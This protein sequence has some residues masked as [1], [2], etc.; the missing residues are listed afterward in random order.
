[1]NADRW[2]HLRGGSEDSRS[3]SNG[4][5]CR[6][7][8]LRR[9]IRS[10]A[11]CCASIGRTCRIMVTSDLFAPEASSPSTSS[12][13]ASPART[14]R[15]RVV[16]GVSKASAAAYGGNCT[17]LWAIFDHASRSWKTS[18]LSLL[19]DSPSFSETLPRSG[20]T[21]SGTLYRLPP[22]TR[23]I[24]GNGA[25]LSRLMPTPTVGDASASGSRN[26]AT[27]KAHPGVSLTDWARRDDGRGRGRQK[28]LP[29]PRA[30]EW[31]GVGPIGS[32]SH[33]HRL[34]RGYL[35][36]AMQE[37]AGETGRLSPQFVA[38]MMGFPPGWCEVN[39]RPTETP[40]SRRSSRSSAAPSSSTRA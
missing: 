21:R 13:A 10:R 39:S 32:K 33:S 8:G 12:A 1:M 2:R 9:S 22:L 24:F 18:A 25:G 28:L 36:A 23:P 6:R 14:F 37:Q 20:M 27:S 40:S 17:E 35:D 4:P 16:V 38:W 19:E 11:R 30:S 7:D 31:K 3:G 5:G 15:S 29:T 34:S 26:T